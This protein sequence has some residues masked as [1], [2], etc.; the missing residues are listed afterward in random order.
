MERKAAVAPT[1]DELLEGAWRNLDSATGVSAP[2][3]ARTSVRGIERE[4]A[5]LLEVMHGLSEGARR[6]SHE[7]ELAAARARAQAAG[8]HRPPLPPPDEQL[9]SLLEAYLAEIVSFLR[10]QQE[11]LQVQLL[12]SSVRRPAA[13]REAGRL[14]AILS[15]CSDL[16]SMTGKHPHT[17]VE[18]ASEVGGGDDPRLTRAYLDAVASFLKHYAEQYGS[19][20]R[21]REVGMALGRAPGGVKMRSLIARDPRFEITDDRAQNGGDGLLRLRPARGSAGGLE[22]EARD[23]TP[24]GGE[25]AG[26]DDG[27]AAQAGAARATVKLNEEGLDTLRAL[28]EMSKQLGSTNLNKNWPTD[29]EGVQQ[30]LANCKRACKPP[31]QLSPSDLFHLLKRAAIVSYVGRDLGSEESRGVRWNPSVIQHSRYCAL[32]KQ[33]RHVHRR[34]QRVTKQKVTSLPS[35]RGPLPRAHRTRWTHMLPTLRLPPL[36]PRPTGGGKRPTCTRSTPR[37]IAPSAD[38]RWNRERREMTA[39]GARSPPA[40]RTR[41]T[42]RTATAFSRGGHAAVGGSGRL[43]PGRCGRRAV[44]CYSSTQAF[45]SPH[46]P[47]RCAPSRNVCALHYATRHWVACARWPT[48]AKSSRCTGRSTARPGARKFLSDPSPLRE[49]GGSGECCQR[50]SGSPASSWRRSR[51]R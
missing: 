5:A 14:N 28:R 13:L 11:P 43:P 32:M 15:G 12:G 40:P 19:A 38:S 25:A 50:V 3:V 48:C 21:L 29:R 6:L 46:S 16:F 30:A 44:C 36:P 9:D 23:S 47:R 39:V 45:L 26:S 24:N 41:T 7:L 17:L 8:A 49:A 27:G 33:R 42:S 18:L 34:R 31:L 1:L 51:A 35:R 4:A 2:R 22:G 10:Q 37:R 20:P